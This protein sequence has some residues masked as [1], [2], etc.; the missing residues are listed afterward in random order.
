MNNRICVPFE[1]KERNE[2]TQTLKTLSVPYLKQKQTTVCHWTGVSY[3]S[4]AVIWCLTFI[5]VCRTRIT[6]IY[7]LYYR[8]LPLF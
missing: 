6:V 2:E 3:V 7:E 5:T 4:Y 8:T 1:V